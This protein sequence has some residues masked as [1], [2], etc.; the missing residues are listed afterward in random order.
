MTDVSKRGIWDDRSVATQLFLPAISF[1]CDPV[2]P[3]G[4][5]GGLALI[6][7]YVALTTDGPAR[8]SVD[9]SGIAQ[10]TFLGKQ[11]SSA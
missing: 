5:S 7:S 1:T 10:H 8:T 9:Q 11:V 3:C 2:R 4:T 6:W